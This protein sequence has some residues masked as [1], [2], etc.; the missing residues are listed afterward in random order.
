MAK[1]STSNAAKAKRPVSQ[2]PAAMESSTGMPQ[3]MAM[4]KRALE[5]T[6]QSSPAKKEAKR[7]TPCSPL[8]DAGMGRHRTCVA[9]V[10]NSSVE[11]AAA[12]KNSTT[13]EKNW[14]LHFNGEDTDHTVSNFSLEFNTESQ[15]KS[16]ALIAK[17]GRTVIVDGVRTTLVKEPNQKSLMRKRFVAYSTRV[18]TV[19]VAD[20]II[21]A[22]A[23]GKE[24]LIRGQEISTG[25]PG[26]VGAQGHLNFAALVIS[27][28]N[29]YIEDGHAVKEIDVLLEDGTE[30]TVRLCGRHASREFPLRQGG[31]RPL[32]FVEAAMMTINGCKLAVMESSHCSVN[33]HPCWPSASQLA[34]TESSAAAKQG[35][36]V[37]VASEFDL[38]RDETKTLGFLRSLDGKCPA[39]VAGNLYACCGEIVGTNMPEKLVSAHNT[40]GNYLHYRPMIKDD[41]DDDASPVVVSFFRNEAVTALGTTLN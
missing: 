37:V 2:P 1:G 33:E 19:E 17:K 23:V 16:A 12:K 7:D 3:V 9:V 38:L 29:Q 41:F 34:I 40:Q 32:L 6:L 22:T 18:A 35:G 15:A 21:V 39:L 24:C 11:I 26:I 27:M 25:A 5:S 30:A 31:L 13:G 4:E 10:T 28:S 20:T 36:L 14:V 8:K